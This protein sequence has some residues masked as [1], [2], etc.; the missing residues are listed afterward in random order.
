MKITQDLYRG[1][2]ATLTDLYQLTMAYGYWKTGVGEKQSVFNLFFRKNPFEGGFTLACGLEYVFDFLNNFSFSEENIEHIRSLEGADGAP[3]FDEDFLKYLKNLEFTCDIEAV[4][5]GTVM[6]PHEPMIRVKGPIVQCQLIESPLLNIINFQS[7]IATKSARINRAAR[8]DAVV[9]FGLRRAQ[10]IDGALAASRASYIGGCQSTSNVKAGDLFGIPVIGTHAHSWV[11]SFDDE[12]DAFRS[13]ASVLPNN[14]VFLVDTYD[15]IQG[16]KNAITIGNELRAKGKEMLGIRIDSGD[17]AYFSVR[18]RKLLD[19]AGFPNAK[20]VA[21][22][23]LDE[24]IISSLKRQDAAID[25]WGIGTKLV[26]AYDQPALGAVYKLAA[27]ENEGKWE[28]KIKL[29]EQAIKVN[30][31]GIQQVR[32]FSKDG[33]Y[34]SDMIYDVEKP[35]GKTHK[36][37]DPMDPTR[38]KSINSDKFEYRDLL[39]S[40]FKEGKLIYDSPDIHSIRGKAELELKQLDKSVKRFVN[41]HNYPVG[42]EASLYNDKI[43]LIMK[44]RTPKDE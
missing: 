1:S 14:C 16:V 3:L 40:I 10:G 17:L 41:P 15:T 31:P 25:T 27:I 4:P 36:I 39:V 30:N 33:C 23:D 12:L 32:R 28:Y 18:A 43:E 7:L 44:L 29:S 11:M 5:E 19:Q 13:Y 42:L 38:R 22:N 2:L 24:H 37:I 26:T 34:F 20:I 21:S 9:E 35:L 8:G 6:F